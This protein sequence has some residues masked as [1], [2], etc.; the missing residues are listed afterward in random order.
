M[1]LVKSIVE[2]EAHGGLNK[3]Y[4]CIAV[5]CYTWLD[6]SAGLCL[7][8]VCSSSRV[9]NRDRDAKR[10]SNVYGTC[11]PFVGEGLLGI[12]ASGPHTVSHGLLLRSECKHIMSGSC[13]WYHS[14]ACSTSL[15][16]LWSRIAISLSF[17]YTY[18]ILLP[19]VH[20]RLPECTSDGWYDKIWLHNTDT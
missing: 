10:T 19:R 8:S 16:L 6:I 7:R 14:S 11:F 13:W 18:S 20:L 15:C 3:R 1:P 5:L 4:S 2:S 12:C 17:V 9:G